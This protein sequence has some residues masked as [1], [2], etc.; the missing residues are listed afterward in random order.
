MMGMILLG[1]VYAVYIPFVP[2]ITWFTA[3]ISYFA[4]VIEGLI[5][6]Q[7][8]AFSHLH[9]DGDGMGQR[10]SRGYIYIL[11][12]LLRPGLMVMGFFFAMGI[13]TL[14]ATFFFAQFASALANVQGETMTGPFI[15][16]GVLSLVMIV[17]VSLIQ[18]TF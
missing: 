12:M 3:L 11:N 18:T 14:L 7:V 13:S 2:F 9:T 8:W 5:A 4:S 16:F 10:A 6:A 15:M 17:M 1:I